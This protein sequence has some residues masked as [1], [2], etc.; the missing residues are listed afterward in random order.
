MTEPHATEHWFRA[1]GKINLG[2][3]VGPVASDGYHPLKTVFQAVDL[4]E[5][6]EIRAADTLSVTFAGPVD[7]GDLIGTDTLVHRAA[8]LVAEAAGLEPMPGAHI[9][10]LKRVPI[11]GG[12]GGGSA[13]AAATLVA[14]N[15]VWNAGLDVDQLNDL[16]AT[17]GADVPFALHGG[18]KFGT[19]RGDELVD[20]LCHAHYTWL[21]VPNEHGLSTPAVYRELDRIREA[22]VAKQVLLDADDRAEVLIAA[23]RQGDPRALAPTLFNDLDQAACS[24]H[25]DLERIRQ[26]GLDAGALAGFV[27]GSGPTMVFLTQDNEHALDVQL[28][29][30]DSGLESIIVH[31]PVKGAL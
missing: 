17:L 1:P 24:L 15:S 20:V 25:P 31:G 11:A 9:E 12:M 21:L 29:L 14:C 2:L 10:V 13:D 30:R 28:G 4:C 26:A 3:A 19:G 16:A 18:T 8:R 5:D 22:G 27:S 23:L 7:T 6:I